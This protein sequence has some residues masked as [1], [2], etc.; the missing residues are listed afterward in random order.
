MALQKIRKVG[1]DSAGITIP[2]DDLRLEGLLDED[3]ELEQGHHVELIR[4]DDGV[5]KMKR[6]EIDC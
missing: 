5:W 6:V 4:V 2:R 3:E 1:G